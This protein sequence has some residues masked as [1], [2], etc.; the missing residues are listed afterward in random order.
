MRGEASKQQSMLVLRSAEDLVSRD[1]PLRRVKALADTALKEL[2]PVFDEMYAQGGR[3]SVPPERLLKASLLMAFYSVRSERL[4][5]E[6]LGYNLLFRWFLDMDMVEDPF[7]HSSFSKNRA[8]LMQHDV[9]KLFFG[10]VVE[11]A[12]AARLTSSEHFSVDGTLIDAW[13][14]FKSFQPKDL[15][16][17]RQAR[18]R[19]KAERKRGGGKGPKGGGGRNVEV[20]FHG[21]KRTNDTHQ[22]TTDPE[23]K[24]MKKGDG[25]PARLS[26]AGHALMENRNGLLVDFR[27]SEANGRAERDTA[28][29]MLVE[30]L[31]GSKP[32]TVGADKGYDSREFV[33]QCRHY[34]VVPHIAQHKTGRRSAIDHRTTR[35]HSYAVSQRIRKRIEEAFGWI[36]TI[37]NFRRTRYKGRERTQLAAHLVAAAYNLI[38]MAKLLPQ[39]T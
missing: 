27:I 21:Q 19:K 39:P 24:L 36:K 30:E 29:T 8:R 4:F 10:K 34:G 12:Q 2:S 11:E 22:S 37:G 38:R 26:Y 31:P 18:N 13:A 5:C 1:H 35:H 23:A 14:S 3:D 9:A 33:E 6:Q 17:E 32:I 25:Q 7:D 16:A 20:N 28:L 15:T